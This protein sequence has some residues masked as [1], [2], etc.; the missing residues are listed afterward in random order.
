MLDTQIATVN[1]EPHNVSRVD[2]HKDTLLIFGVVFSLM[3]SIFL[4]DIKGVYYFETGERNG[5]E[6]FEVQDPGKYVNDLSNFGADSK[7]LYISSIAFYHIAGADHKLEDD[8]DLRGILWEK[9]TEGY[10]GNVAFV[11]FSNGPLTV[12]NITFLVPDGHSGDPDEKFCNRAEATLKHF[13]ANYPNYKWYFRGIHDTFVNFTALIEV[14]KELESKYDPMKEFAMAY[15]CHEYNYK[16]YPHGGTGYLFSNY[17][18]KKF[19][20]NMDRFLYHCSGIADDVGLTDFMKSFGIDVTKFISSRF[21]VTWPNTQTDVLLKRQYDAVPPCP[22]YYQLY[23]NAPKQYP[24]HIKT[25]AS[26]H[27]HKIKMK[28]MEHLLRITP[29]DFAV[30]YLDPN[31]PRFCRLVP[32]NS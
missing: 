1:D 4:S 17:A 5:V 28:D 24:C 6:R 9:Q 18:V 21:I 26:L 29:E 13:V 16:L 2:C 12:N 20:E 19:V 15:N 25:A 3:I 31:S 32:A 7:D 8:V 14:I 10:R 11:F 30:T 22:D 27:M 23:K